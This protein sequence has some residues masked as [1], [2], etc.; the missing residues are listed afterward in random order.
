LEVEDLSLPRLDLDVDDIVRRYLSDETAQGIACS[1]GV[2]TK[3]ISIPQLAVGPYNIDLAIGNVAVEVDGRGGKPLSRP[4]TRQRVE[5]LL[6]RG[7]NVYYIVIYPKVTYPPRR[8]LKDLVPFLEA[9]N[10]T[11]ARRREYRVVRSS[12]ELMASGRGYIDH[13]S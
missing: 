11:P 1:L 3:V 6:N 10:R 12:G 2:T 8:V 4:D 7:W 9:A 5:D 13:L